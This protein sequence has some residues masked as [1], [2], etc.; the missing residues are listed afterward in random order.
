MVRL[1][2]VGNVQRI[3]DVQNDVAIQPGEIAEIQFIERSTRRNVR[4]VA[5]VEA[6]GDDDGPVRG[7]VFRH[8][9]GKGEITAFVSQA[10]LAI[11]PDVGQL[12]S[13]PG[14]QS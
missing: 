10:M 2:R 1:D 12:P 4:I 8:I 13:R 3:G 11:D 14:I 7:D 5:V 6:H 9:D